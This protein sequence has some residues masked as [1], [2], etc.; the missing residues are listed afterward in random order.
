MFYAHEYESSTR[1]L[2]RCRVRALRTWATLHWPAEAVTSI[3]K[4]FA[5]IANEPAKNLDKEFD[6]LED[7]VVYY[8]ELVQTGYKN[9]KL[10]F[11]KSKLS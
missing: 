6:R 7:A 5:V 10:T 9:V 8:N 11:S 1:R 3:M 4:T 2:G